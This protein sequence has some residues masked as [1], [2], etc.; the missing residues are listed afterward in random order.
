VTAVKLHWLVIATTGLL[1][2]GC[3]SDKP[4]ETTPPKEEP[5]PGEVCD[6][7]NS[8]DVRFRF[9]PPSLVLAPG[10]TR[11]VRLIVDPDIC[12]PMKV[13]VTTGNADIVKAPES[14]TFGLRKPTH[15]FLITGGAQGVTKLTVTGQR[16]YDKDEG[17]AP[18]VGELEI[19]VRDGAAPRCGGE[20]TTH[21]MSASEPSVKGSGLL[22]GTFMAS[23]ASAFGRSDELGLPEFPV[24]L[25]CE[26]DMA[27]NR[28]ALG[29]AVSFLSTSAAI[30]NIKPLR[31]ELD[32]SIPVNPAAIPGPGRLR[33]V[34]ILYQGP[35][36]KTARPVAVTNLRI[37]RFASRYVA[38]FSS[39]WLGTYQAI[40]MPDAGTVKK[41]KLLTHRAVIGFSMGGGGAAMFGL[42]HHDKFDA[43]GPLGGPSD[44]TW[45]SW[46]IESYPLG[47]FCPASNPTCTRS[48]P[49]M[50]PIDEPLVHTM[51]FNHWW[52]EDGN[53]NGGRFPRSE[54]ISLLTDI[55]TMMGNPNGENADP[56]LAHYPA[57]P[58]ANDPFV[59]GDT[60]GF[61][62]G[63]DCRLI[64][65]PVK[66]ETDADKPQE[67]AQQRYREQ[68]NRSRCSRANTWKAPT[69]YYDDEYNPDGSKQ[70]ISFCDGRQT[71]E[72]PYQNTWVQP[73]DGEGVPVGMALAV[74]LNGNGIR[75][76]DEPVIRSGHE[77]YD[78]FGTD[79]LKNEQEPGYDPVTNPDPNQDDYDYLINPGGTEGDHR[80]Q[81]GEPFKDFGL[82]GVQGTPQQSAGGFDV[83]EGDGKYTE[84]RGLK[85]LY[86]NDAH[87][88]LRQWSTD[89]PAG[90]LTD[91]KLSRV[92]FWLDGGVRDLFNLAVV[93]HHLSGAIAS[94]GKPTGFYSGF[95]Y[96]P[97]QP[98]DRP[99][100]FQPANILW[101]DVPG[102]PMVR[103]G[104]V[105]A[106]PQQIK[107]G[108][109][110]HVGTAS[111]L[112]Y[113]LES[114]FYFL[115]NL[116]P[117]ADRA[118]TQLTVDNPA[119]ET[120][121]ELG[122]S[123]EV[124]N[125]CEKMFTGP[126]TRR[127]GP[128]AVT[129]PPGYA[130]EHNRK[131]DVRYPVVYVLHGY[132]Q[133]PRDLEAVALITNNFMNDGL[134]SSAT[135]LAKFI[136]VYVDGRC[137]M[138]KDGKPECMQGSFYMNSA[139]PG[140]PQFDAWFDEVI[141]YVDKNYRT[142]K[143]T[144]IEVTE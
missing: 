19:D 87:S 75:D 61:P 33:H 111:Q 76:E 64:L 38:R 15:D 44:W 109:G 54:Y 92:S 80:W 48:K 29:P 103:Y 22:A 90:A 134:R 84:S 71:G 121:N 24:E 43:I 137:R 49:N 14:P 114:A 62:E 50:W 2:K 79:G 18:A 83:G 57:G 116:W 133:D 131:R 70:V 82:D 36:A 63:L 95:E 3:G 93:G 67:Q 42:R 125:R 55:A 77:P 106:T 104:A 78:D 26:A 53:G 88:I 5:L 89:I 7:T 141:D 138:G 32:F 127:T 45:L 94:R 130:N 37:E 118:N 16:K 6:P 17:R 99:L 117:G 139:R 132:G 20:S 91:D 40:A 51:D 135:R 98:I 13:E 28:V 21:T 122:V 34:Q 101:A 97:G 66:A 112:L 72:S 126:K 110:M 30:S 86:A 12:E 46:Y 65:E 60:T 68:C 128:I 120:I 143:P 4:I 142:M 25:K 23:P 27:G 144:E 119:S 113:R 102:S 73:G 115:A 96:L 56:A 85:N 52:Y 9:D 136:V 41:K 74:D 47:G 10:M 81:Q 100:D 11:P 35:R 59:K 69:G 107:N 105:D 1:L 129:L 123:C 140:G 124:Q 39:P 31:R 58:T 108:D 8:A